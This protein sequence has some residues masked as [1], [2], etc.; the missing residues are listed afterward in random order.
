[1]N[2]FLKLSTM[3]LNTHKIIKIEK[4]GSKYQVHLDPISLD[5]LMLVGSG[6]IKTENNIITICQKKNDLDYKIMENWVNGI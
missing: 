5:G 3:V 6:W 1:M 2:R 4:Y